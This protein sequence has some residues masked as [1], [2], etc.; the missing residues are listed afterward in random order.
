[1][2]KPNHLDAGDRLVC[3]LSIIAGAFFVFVFGVIVIGQQWFSFAY[4][5]EKLLQNY[6][7]LLLA[8]VFIVLS[9]LVRR[10]SL[11]RLPIILRGNTFLII[12][13]AVLLIIQLLITR[14][15]WFYAGWDVE[16]VY[17]TALNIA[18]GLPIANDY[19]KSCPN[20][21]PIALLLSYPLRTALWLG[22]DVPYSVLPYL[23]TVMVNLACFICMLCVRKATKSLYALLGALA[24]TTVWI[25][26]SLISTIPYTDTFSILFPILVIFVYMS[27]LHLF[28]KAFFMSFIAFLGASI[29]PTVLIALF[30]PVVMVVLAIITEQS[31]MKIKWARIGLVV[32]ALFIGAIPGRLWT[33]YA[34]AELAGSANPPEK[35]GIT[36]F[37][38]MGM[39]SDTYGG[40]DARDVEYSASFDSPQARREAEL[41][42]AWERFSGRSIAE[43][44]EFF[45]IKTYK[46][47]GDGTMASSNSFFD[48]YV[49]PRKDT[50][51]VFLSSLLY[52][53]GSRNALLQTIQ[54]TIWLMVLI[55][56]IVALLSKSRYQALTALLGFT[57]LG[58][59]CYQLLFE[60]WPRYLYLY[61][62]IFVLLAVIGMGS[63]SWKLCGS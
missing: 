63:Y 21:A 36:R 51:A 3:V 61:M 35:Q 53:S 30:M 38:L 46:A 23:S 34:T 18:S 22:K 62:P 52:R 25:G 11:K 6:W 47:F 10:I 16:T 59:G 49:P 54:Q 4:L 8:V 60:V 58:V 48:L 2:D 37:L 41:S 42:L 56:V 9:L 27:K 40:H 13:F 29:K 5:Q 55:F 32:L 50:L 31:K 15:V 33:Q 12:Y 28:P 19:F 26:F 43:N 17:S 14:S 57:L 39:N 7:L 24:L 45:S 20:N 1:M 44:M